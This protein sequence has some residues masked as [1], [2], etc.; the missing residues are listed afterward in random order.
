MQTRT[1]QNKPVSIAK[2]KLASLRKKLKNILK[3]K[4]RKI[5]GKVRLALNLFGSD[6]LN[7]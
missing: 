5:C 3:E 4:L 2:N 7:N 6:G 1:K